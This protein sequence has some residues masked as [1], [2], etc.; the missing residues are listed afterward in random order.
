MLRDQERVFIFTAYLAVG[1]QNPMVVVSC[2]LGV[3]V[4]CVGRV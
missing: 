2:S 4:L 1:A 3:Q